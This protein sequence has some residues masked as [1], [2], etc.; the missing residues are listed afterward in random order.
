MRAAILLG[1]GLAIGPAP[2]LAEMDVRGTVEAVRIEARD[3]PVQDILAAL[4]RTFGMHYQLLVNVDKR[5][6][7]TYVGSLSRVLARILDGYNFILKTDN[8]T[9]ALMVVGTPY[10]PGTFPMPPPGPF[11]AQAVRQPAE[12]A[13]PE[14]AAA[15][16]TGPA[17]AFQW[18]GP[19][20]VA[21]ARAQARARARAQQSA[22][23]P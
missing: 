12:A 6:S 19:N 16:T 15:A 10:P 17:P 2:A 14:P 5:L 7:G 11:P 23:T 18:S 1:A 3:A 8:G 22:K 13:P 21:K 4:D 20:P 9:I